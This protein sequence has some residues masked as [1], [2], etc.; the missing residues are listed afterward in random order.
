VTALNLEGMHDHTDTLERELCVIGITVPDPPVR[1]LNFFDNHGL[2]LH[3]TW[4]VGGQ[5]GRRLLK[6]VMTTAGATKAR[7][8]HRYRAKQGRHSMNSSFFDMIRNTARRAMRARK[9]GDRRLAR[10]PYLLQARQHL[11]CFRQH[12]P[13]VREIAKAFGP[14]SDTSIALSHERRQRRA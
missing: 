14:N 11:L 6:I 5:P 13:Q 7:E 10:R 8:P 2:W 9:P 4:R 1:A 3:S 12:Q